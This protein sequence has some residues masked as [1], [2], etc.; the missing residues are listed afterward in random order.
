[1][2][3]KKHNFD[4]YS[5]PMTPTPAMKKANEAQAN[6][7]PSEEQTTTTINEKDLNNPIKAKSKEFLPQIASMIG[8]AVHG[9]LYKSDLLTAFEELIPD[10]E[11]EAQKEALI[12]AQKQREMDLQQQS[13]KTNQDEFD[14]SFLDQSHHQAEVEVQVEFAQDELIQDELIQDELIQDPESSMEP[15]FFHQDQLAIV[16]EFDPLQTPEMYS[17]TQEDL[18]SNES[19]I[20]ETAPSEKPVFDDPFANLDDDHDAPR[21]FE[22]DEFNQSLKRKNQK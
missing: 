21:F 20:V 7:L 15:I 18:L 10:P 16:E 14:F 17:Q 3:L 13:I 6:A 9:D 11:K 5:T 2:S 4:L 8:R 1:M 22:D 19:T 12:Q